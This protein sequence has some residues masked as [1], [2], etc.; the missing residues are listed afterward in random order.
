MRMNPSKERILLAYVYDKSLS[1]LEI[2][3]R[4]KEIRELIRSATGVL[5][6][7]V[8]AP[9]ARPSA[10]FYVG[11]GK[12]EQL[13][14]EADRAGA[15]TFVFSVDLTPSQNRNLENVFLRTVVDRTGL[16]LD[17]FAR[18]AQTKEGKLQVEL[19]QHLYLLP[20]LEGRGVFLS[21]LGGGIGTRG[22]GEQKLEVDRRKIRQ[23]IERLKAEL[24]HI[25]EHRA[26]LRSGRDRKQFVR[27]AL[28]GY[29]NA[30]KS[31]LLNAVTK[32]HVRTQD[33]MF[34][35]LDPTTRQLYL[36]SSD[37]HP[38]SSPYGSN[39][40][41]ILLTDTVGMLA[42]LPHH[43]IEAFQATLEEVQEADVL[44]HVVDV[45]HSHFERQY[46]A[47]E[48]ELERMGLGHRKRILVLNKIDLLSKEIQKSVKM[49]YPDAVMISAETGEGLDML[50][51][52][53]QTVLLS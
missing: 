6:A 32:S 49:K 5:A 11:E 31:T 8:D 7:E 52:T 35:T 28:V 43:L 14:A 37:A 2:E 3:E 12:V 26:R 44:I 25:K 30:G 10:K 47:V 18:R 41:R 13:R 38:E 9:V 42:D 33:L 50:R 15:V 45:S 23:R 24:E 46:D 1:R 36:A 48:A 16:I 51:K 39:G 17:I 40:R 27:A 34:A 20:R 19:A 22:P 29:T 4:R 21:R 53:I